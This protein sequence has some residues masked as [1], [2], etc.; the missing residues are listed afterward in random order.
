MKKA[1]IP[2]SILE[3]NKIL[4]FLCY[5]Y[6]KALIDGLKLPM[7]LLPGLFALQT[8]LARRTVGCGSL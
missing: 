3:L 6:K 5:R 2:V 4:L 8:L 1:G 7:V